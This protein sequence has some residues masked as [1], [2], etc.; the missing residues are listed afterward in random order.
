MTSSTET[1]RKGPAERVK[2][3]AAACEGSH[4]RY[5]HLL[6]DLR[7]EL[8]FR[9]RP[10]SKLLLSALGGPFRLAYICLARRVRE[11]RVASG[12]GGEDLAFIVFANWSQ[13]PHYLKIARSLELLLREAARR[14]GAEISVRSLQSV[15]TKLSLKAAIALVAQTV[16]A[17]IGVAILASRSKAVSWPTAQATTLARCVRIANYLHSSKTLGDGLKPAF[18]VVTISENW[19]PS[20]LAIRVAKQH[21]VWTLHYPH[22]LLNPIVLPLT[23]DV[24]LLWNSQMVATY[25]TPSRNHS[26]AVG[27][28]EGYQGVGTPEIQPDCDV[29][30][31]SQYLVYHKG[32][33]D[34][35][36]KFRDFFIVWRDVL[37]RRPG[38]RCLVKMH[39]S[40]G[41]GE[42]AAVQELFRDVHEQVEIVPGSADLQLALKRC[43]LHSTVSSGTLLTAL[44]L[45]KPTLVYQQQKPFE[46][47]IPEGLTVFTSADD[48]EQQ[49]DCIESTEHALPDW[50]RD[51]WIESRFAEVYKRLVSTRPR[52]Q[53]P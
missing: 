8:F 37:T 39:P 10:K 31:S 1:K 51:D 25:A 23:S 18:A 11:T 40:D 27:F 26:L 22:G 43:R 19:M 21:N 24:Q 35:E 41:R 20:A 17:V 6:F 3:I 4:A 53:S 47:N 14:D 12:D 9:D 15:V 28:V 30:L 49:I 48:L 7:F 44:K 52:A 36:R 32:W 13:S 42:L 5:R 2:C 50:L 33:S 38:M 29:L 16:V 34:N 45:N 46:D